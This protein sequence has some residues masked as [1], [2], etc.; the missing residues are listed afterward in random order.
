M[1]IHQIR[2]ATMIIEYDGIKFLVDPM[3]APKGE[4]NG[5]GVDEPI[6][7]V[8]WP[9]HDLPLPPKDIIKNID[10]VILTHLHTDH[11]DKFAQEILPKGIKIFVQDIFD[12]FALE[13]EHFTDIEILDES[14]T[15]FNGIKLYKTRCMHGV[16]EDAEFIFLANGMRWE[17]MGVVFSADNEPTLYLTGDTILFDGVKQTIDAYKPKYTVVNAD[18]SQ[19]SHSGPLNMGVNDIKELHEYYPEGKLFVNHLDC[20]GY[21]TLSRADLRASEV[22][23]YIYPPADGEMM[24]LD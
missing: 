14:G 23:D 19:I 12:K 15:E 21:S 2:N 10:A 24:L 17:A 16:R 13:K 18:C 3:F 4:V 11:F 9:L 6:I 5:N 8:P 20:V 7:D 1:R 22:K